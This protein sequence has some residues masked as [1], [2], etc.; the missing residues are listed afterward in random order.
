MLDSRSSDLLVLT[1]VAL[2]AAVRNEADLTEPLSPDA[3]A[4]SAFTQILLLNS[5]GLDCGLRFELWRIVGRAQ[6]GGS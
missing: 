3:V 1:R 6:T 5:S 4:M 2:Q